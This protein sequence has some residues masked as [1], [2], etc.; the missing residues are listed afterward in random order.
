MTGRPAGGD[1]VPADVGWKS[2]ASS[3]IKR[4]AAIGEERIGPDD[5]EAVM[6]SCRYFMQQA[7][8]HRAGEWTSAMERSTGASAPSWVTQAVTQAVSKSWH[9]KIAG[10]GE[11]VWS[12]RSEQITASGAHDASLAAAERRQIEETFS[13]QGVWGASLKDAGEP[14]AAQA[15]SSDHFAP[16]RAEMR[17]RLD[18]VLRVADR[19]KAVHG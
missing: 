18:A 11:S 8:L 12:G 15:A 13:G 17:R 10:L 5:Y 14:S 1:R 9:A 4:V 2:E 7:L 6:S 16:D 19:Y 3:L